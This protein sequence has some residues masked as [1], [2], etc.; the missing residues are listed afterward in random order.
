M[1]K[2]KF[3]YHVDPIKTKVIKTDK[4]VTCECCAK[5]TPIYYD[6]S[7]YA[8]DE[9]EF[10]CPECI[11]TGKASD[12]FKGEFQQSHDEVSDKNK[13]DALCYRT[14]G[15]I[16][17]QGEHWLAHCDDFCAFVD[18]VGWKEIAEMGLESEIED[19][20][21]NES[22]RFDIAVIKQNMK[23]DGD[24]QGYLFRCLICGKHRLYVDCS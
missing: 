6:G 22:H 11:S 18:Y 15:Y 4:V 23:N 16:S 17:W 5:E 10:L 2:I 9:V 14:P 24:M 7:F 8:V 12:K 13:I 1:S 19:D 3:K 20:L 21:T